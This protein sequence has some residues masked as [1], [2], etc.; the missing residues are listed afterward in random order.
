MHKLEKITFEYQ[1]Y[2]GEYSKKLLETRKYEN[3]IIQKFLI[4]NNDENELLWQFSRLD[5]QNRLYSVVFFVDENEKIIPTSKYSAFCFFPTKVNTHLNFVIHAPFLLTDSR[6][7]I[8]ANSE[9]NKKMI[10]NL[11]ELSADCIEYFVKIGTEKNIRI[12][13]DNIINIVPLDKSYFSVSDANKIGFRDFYDK[14]QSKIKKGF[15]PTNSGY[16]SSDYAYWADTGALNSLISK[17]QLSALMQ[18]KC[19][20]VFTSQGKRNNDK[21]ANY[22]AEINV[23]HLRMDYVLKQMS[24]QFISN[25]TIEWLFELYKNILNN[26]RNVE[27]SKNLP[28]FFNS[29]REACAAYKN[30]EPFL[31][32]SSPNSSGYN[33]ILDEIQSNADAFRLLTKLE[34]R[35]PSLKDKIFQKVLKKTVFEANDIKDILDYYTE[36]SSD[37]KFINELKNKKIWKIL[38]RDNYSLASELYYPDATLCKYFEGTD[39]LF[40]D[41][42][43]Y[44]RIIPE[45]NSNKFENLLDLIGIERKPRIKERNI[46]ESDFI[47]FWKKKNLRNIPQPSY[48]NWYSRQY[49]EFYLDGFVEAVMRAEKNHDKNLSIILW[50]ILKTAD[51]GKFYSNYFIESNLFQ[52]RYEY[53]NRSLKHELVDGP[54]YYQVKICKWLVDNDDVFVSPQETYWE[55]LSANYDV[56]SSKELI[57]RFEIKSKPQTPLK[58]GIP[59]YDFETQQKLD[60][61]NEIKRKLSEAG[62]NDE[63]T[64]DDLEAIKRN[65][66][67]SNSKQPPESGDTQSSDNTNGKRTP[68]EKLSRDIVN[69]AQELEGKEPPKEETTDN[70]NDSDEWTPPSFNSKKQIEKAK[71]KLAI[72]LNRIEELEKAK[73]LATNSDVYTY[74]W[75]KSMLQ[76]E[77]LRSNENNQNSREVRISFGKVEIDPT[78][79]KTLILSQPNKKIPVFIEE[80]YGINLIIHFRGDSPD[81]QITFEAASIRSFTLRLKMMRNEDVSNLNVNDIASAEIIAKSPVFLLQE[82]QKQFDSLQM[83][84]STNLKDTLCENIRFVFGPPGTGKT[85]FLAEKVLLPWIEEHESCNILVLTPT[86]KAADVLTKRIMEK[87]NQYSDFLLRFGT[88]SD[89]LIENSGVFCNR[90]FDIS[91]RPQNIVVTTIARLPYDSFVKEGK[92]SLFIRDIEWDYI[93]VDEASMIPLIHM[94]YLLNSQKPTEFVIAGDPFQIEP[95]VSEESWKK[96]NIYEMVGLKNFANPHT[97]PHSYKVERLEKQYR[98]I[99]SVGEI[100][101]N[102]TYGGILQH[103]RNEDE[104]KPLKIDGL[105]ANVLNIIKFPVSRYESIYRCKRLGLGS[106]YQIYSALFSYEFV[107]HLVDSIHRKYAGHKYSIGIISP[108]KAEADLIGNLLRTKKLPDSVSV[109]CGTVHSFQGDECDIMLTVFNTPEN[110]TTSDKM[111]LNH[112]NIINVAVSR[113]RDYLFVLMPDDETK[114]IENL[115]LVNQLKTLMEKSGICKQFHSQE[116]EKWMFGNEKFLEENAFSTGHQSVNVYGEPEKCYEIRSEEDAIDIQIHQN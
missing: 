65:R 105:D 89:E 73:E 19:D 70:D 36:Y 58:I 13:D 56:S 35:K 6:E 1:N 77:I 91:T 27:L 100:Y 57:K 45:M 24:K 96:E 64:D 87:T 9:Y 21:L 82:L 51:L 14:I 7:G 84:S 108:Y 69:Q 67:K 53:F 102:L 44:H 17:E 48:S 74:Q 88:T 25:Q 78:A 38:G 20:W 40:L 55:N 92:K 110:I 94:V 11:A 41:I 29:Q 85:T 52:I 101:S 111:F 60:E 81:K 79:Q 59:K 72:E 107:C 76:L 39:T 115:R 16:I 98:S 99:P 113:A 47:K 43:F 112:K 95:T 37:N 66:Q 104:R 12:I 8:K 22:L 93:V 62:V 3:T 33:V 32:L 31:Y 42:D 75:F 49:K 26:D 109:L 23:V 97:V 34:V 30:G 80:L 68:K 50:N 86:N 2:F 18:K 106:N 71:E 4:I 28:I 5:E 90:N 63:L 15:L 83:D 61:L 46:E 10:L 114:S 116:L 54:I 103:K